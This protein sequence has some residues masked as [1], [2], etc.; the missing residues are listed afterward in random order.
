VV[1]QGGGEGKQQEGQGQYQNSPPP[2]PT[3]AKIG[4]LARTMARP[5][6]GLAK[7]TSIQIWIW[8]EM[9]PKVWV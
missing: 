9:S 6:A 5:A 7:I 8:P 3:R 1:E 2:T 4:L